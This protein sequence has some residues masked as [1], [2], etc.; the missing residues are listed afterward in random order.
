MQPFLLS[1]APLQLALL[2]EHPSLNLSSNHN[3]ISNITQE[4][5]SCHQ[6][7][8]PYPRNNSSSVLRCRIRSTEGL[9][10][11]RTG[12]I[13]SSSG[14]NHYGREKW[15]RGYVS[16]FLRYL[17]KPAESG[18]WGWEVVR[19]LECGVAGEGSIRFEGL[20]RGSGFVVK[21]I[22]I[23]PDMYF[24]RFSSGVFQ[25]HSF[26]LQDPEEPCITLY[27]YYLRVVI[28]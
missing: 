7:Q 25:L 6:A 18:R 5:H 10:G 16:W 21:H 15:C 14:F 27:C 12:G 8:R 17:T 11:V 4:D 24:N 28:G 26:G 20:C 2:N 23:V 9:R 13:R 3:E 19:I 22:V 1:S